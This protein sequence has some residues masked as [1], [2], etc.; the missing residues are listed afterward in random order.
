MWNWRRR[1]FH[2]QDLER[3]IRSHLDA[4]CAE[5]EGAGLSP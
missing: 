2:E 5:Q 3:E 4:E 1:K